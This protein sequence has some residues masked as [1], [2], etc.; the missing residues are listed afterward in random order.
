MINKLLE[1]ELK[2]IYDYEL[3]GG[4]LYVYA[5]GYKI[6]PIYK[7]DS[8][9][10][11]GFDRGNLIYITNFGSLENNILAFAIKQGKSS[12]EHNA[13]VKNLRKKVYEL[14]ST[15]PAEEVIKRIGLDKIAEEYLKNNNDIK[16][17][18]FRGKIVDISLIK[19]KLSATIFFDKENTTKY[20]LDIIDLI[21]NKTFIERCIKDN[22]LDISPE[23]L[24]QII[25]YSVTGSSTRVKEKQEKN[26][27]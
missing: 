7:I 14:K 8:T 19:D 15:Q 1:K 27:Y 25:C 24:L 4:S 11:G 17:E 18:P 26:T 13:K 12:E 16:I 2:G 23:L 21:E 6:E 10:I 5:K 3:K 9:G 22:M 20:Y